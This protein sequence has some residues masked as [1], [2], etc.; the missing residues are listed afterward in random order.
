MR[1]IL[2]FLITFSCTVSGSGQEQRSV[3]ETGIF[4]N[5]LF[6][7]GSDPWI[8]RHKDYYYYC[9][10]AGNGIMIRRGENLDDLKDSKPAK[11]WTAPEGTM[12]SKE[13]WAPELHFLEGKWYVYFAADD[14]KNKNH[15][16][17]VIENP[18]ADPL[19]GNWTLKGK[20]SDI[21]DR[22]A[23]DGTVFRFRG[24]LYM[25]WSGWEGDVNGQQNLYIA[26][27]KNPWTIS[28]ERVLISAPELLW[29]T[30]GD[31]NNPDDVPHVNVNEGPAALI[32]RGRLFI[33]YSAS[34]CWTDAYCLGMLT[35]K[36]NGDLLNPASWVKNR[37]PVFSGRPEANAYATG[38]SSFFTSPDGKEDWIVYHANPAAGQGCG[39]FRT[40]R[41]QK[42]IWKTDGTPDFGEPVS[43]GVPV[44]L[45]SAKK[46]R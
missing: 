44:I 1:K 3:A 37:E 26:A 38:H 46:P 41:A 21:T 30:V 15:R 17:Y 22:W 8:M 10:S 29:E 13:I 4:T 34:G 9:S 18:S 16:M 27:M 35:L 28:S 32:R 42:F 40:P 11:V 45:P 2:L 14:G 31:L 5:P 33:V 12:W 43:T 6:S 20:V 23:I 39:R 24:R 7:S 25:V 36:G 19:T